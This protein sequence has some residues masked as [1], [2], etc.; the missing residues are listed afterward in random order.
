LFAQMREVFLIMR[1]IEVVVALVTAVANRQLIQIIGVQQSL[2]ALAKRLDTWRPA[3]RNSP[4]SISSGG[5]VQR[6]ANL[7]PGMRS[8]PRYAKMPDSEN[9]RIRS[10]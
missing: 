8:S 7:R 5:R 4:I 2:Q 9:V 10:E 6:A 3:R 1:R